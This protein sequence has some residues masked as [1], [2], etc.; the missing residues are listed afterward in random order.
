MLTDMKEQKKEQK[1]RSDRDQ[2]QATREQEALKRHNDQL[3]A[4]IA[5]LQRAQEHMQ[6]KSESEIGETRTNE[7]VT[8]LRRPRSTSPLHED[9]SDNKADPPT[10]L[11]FLTTAR[12]REESKDLLTPEPMMS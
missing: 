9:Y 6:S 11:S 5:V 4:Q 2:E 12:L 7:P 10:F 1:I 8:N 3:Q